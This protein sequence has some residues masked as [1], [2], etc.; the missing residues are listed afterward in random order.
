MKKLIKK[1]VVKREKGFMY[2]IDGEGNLW[3]AKMK[4]GG[5]KGRKWIEGEDY[6]KGKRKEKLI[7]NKMEENIRKSEDRSKNG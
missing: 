2:Y 7:K 6:Y 5:K 4:R 1:N 3:G